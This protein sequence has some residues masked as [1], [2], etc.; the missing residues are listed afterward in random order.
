MPTPTLPRIPAAAL[1]L[2][3]AAALAACASEAAPTPTPTP[4][5]IAV[6]TGTGDGTR[7]VELE[8]GDYVLDASITDNVD[9]TDEIVCVSESCRER[10]FAVMFGSQQL[11]DVW[12][13][14][15][16]RW[17]GRWP[18]AI[19]EHHR[20]ASTAGSVPVNVEAENPG[21]WSVAIHSAESLPAASAPATL[22]GEGWDVR[23]LDLEEGSYVLDI[24]IDHPFKR[25]GSIRPFLLT[26]G[27]PA[28]Y[29]PSH[30]FI[31][32]PDWS[33]RVFFEVGDY[34]KE[35]P[36]GRLQLEVLSSSRTAW[37]IDVLSAS[38]IPARAAPTTLTGTGQDV[39]FIDLEPGFYAVETRVTGNEHCYV[40]GCE[41]DS[42]GVSIGASVV[43]AKTLAGSRDYA[44]DWS[45]RTVIGVGVGV[46]STRIPPGRHPVKVTATGSA[47]WSIS[48]HPLAPTPTPPS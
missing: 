20:D 45:E 40:G 44:A 12:R 21:R 30:V 5:P 22:R 41:K 2:L 48:I 31:V 4:T 17:S 42:F 7:I 19:G 25:L 9:D 29:W 26:V 11:S 6:L 27:K 24:D 10:L 14:Y 32:G 3:A 46:R 35:N 43:G 36:P 28:S 1:A 8:A 16:R 37:A 38:S 18:I 34:P 13:I 39:R 47:R 15:G 33:G 23:F